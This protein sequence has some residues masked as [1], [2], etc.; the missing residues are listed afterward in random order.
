MDITRGTFLATVPGTRFAV[1][2]IDGE[3]S[4]RATLPDTG[5]TVTGRCATALGAI[6]KALRGIEPHTSVSPG[7]PIRGRVMP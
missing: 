1:A 4:A 7:S 6:R 3:W 2:R 5:R